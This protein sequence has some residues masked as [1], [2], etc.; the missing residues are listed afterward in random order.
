MKEYTAEERIERIEQY[1]CECAALLEYRKKKGKQ[2]IAD[3]LGCVY[4]RDAVRV[5]LYA[6]IIEP[7][8]AAEIMV[9]IDET[10]EKKCP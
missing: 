5:L 4:L 3:K 2:V 7:E 6:G 1:Y 9:R 8:D 10:E